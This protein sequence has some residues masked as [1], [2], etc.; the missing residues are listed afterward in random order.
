MNEHFKDQLYLAIMSEIQANPR[1]VPE[2]RR[3]PVTGLVAAAA[4]LTVAAGGAVFMS[5]DRPHTVSVATDD[6]GPTTTAVDDSAYEGGFVFGV[7]HGRTFLVP[8]ES[9]GKRSSGPNYPAGTVSFRLASADPRVAPMTVSPSADHFETHA[10][11]TIAGRELRLPNGMTPP[12]GATDADVSGPWMWNEADGTQWMAQGLLADLRA[13]LP[14]LDY[15]DGAMVLGP[16]LVAA[17]IEDTA[18]TPERFRVRDERFEIGIADDSATT[19]DFVDPRRGA[20][21]L[22]DIGGRSGIVYAGLGISWRADDH[23]VISLQRST[24]S[25]GGAAPTEDELLAAARSVRPAS[26]AE[27]KAL[28]VWRGAVDERVILRVPE[29]V[30]SEEGVGVR[31]TDLDVVENGGDIGTFNAGVVPFENGFAIPLGPDRIGH[32][33]VF[34]L[35]LNDGELGCPATVTV[36][37]QG[38]EPVEVEL[39]LDC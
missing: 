24:A 36:P 38:A 3:V 13:A 22:V 23:T 9:L 31:L 17:P 34:R 29:A 27:M 15:T 14:D 19:F 1:A 30:R 25:Y 6:T 7:P 8:T 5:I 4:V 10:V 18:P 11:E 35:D 39:P 33:L 21:A 2:P 20:L 26:V 32:R 28:R 37:P 16:S 12:D